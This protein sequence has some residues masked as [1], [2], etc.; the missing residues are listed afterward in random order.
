MIGKCRIKKR[1][2]SGQIYVHVI[3]SVDYLNLQ[4]FLTLNYFLI[5]LALANEM[6]K[7]KPFELNKKRALGRLYFLP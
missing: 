4:R 7:Y 1:G 3:V 2:I 6:L 5:D